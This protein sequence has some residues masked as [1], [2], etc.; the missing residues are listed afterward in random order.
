MLFTDFFL[1]S[2]AYYFLAIENNAFLFFHS[3]YTFLWI[4]LAFK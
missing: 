2:Y 4:M 1:K 3:F